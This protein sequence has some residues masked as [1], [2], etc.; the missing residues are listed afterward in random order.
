MSS[1]KIECV[2]RENCRCGE[3]PVWEE[4]ANSL[5]FVDIPAKK[6]CRWDSLSKSVQ[7]V[8]V[9]KDEGR[10]QIRPHIVLSPGRGGHLMCHS[11]GNFLL[12]HPGHALKLLLGRALSVHTCALPLRSKSKFWMLNTSSSPRA[13][14]NSPHFVLLTR[15]WR[16][17]P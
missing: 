9:G 7:H 11:P 17:F 14:G 8:T 10:A 3:S 6:V 1:I 12:K 15:H 16:I 4:A 2:L 13:R 5:L